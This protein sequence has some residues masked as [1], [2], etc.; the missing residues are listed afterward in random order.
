MGWEGS[1]T[2]EFIPTTDQINRHVAA[3]KICNLQPEVRYDINKMLMEGAVDSKVIKYASEQGIYLTPSNV[4]GHKKYIQYVAEDGILQDTLEKIKANNE[5]YQKYLTEQE[6]QAS[7]MYV[8]VQ[9]AK[10]DQLLH[11]WTETIPTLRNLMSKME[12]N[13]LLPVKDY[14]SS[15]ETMLRCALLIEGKP[16]GRFAV[17]STSNITTDGKV[18][19]SDIDKLSAIFGVDL[20]VNENN[21]E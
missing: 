2:K 20:N 3:C 18:S 19:I 4:S 17:E 12:D 16:T 7:K 8:E 6:E 11:I 5:M 1:F 13:P 21:K 10:N 15:F 14:A 9:Q